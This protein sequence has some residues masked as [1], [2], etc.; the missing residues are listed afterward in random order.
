V[1]DTH[2][3]AQAAG[4]ADA[5]NPFITIYNELMEHPE[6][7]GKEVVCYIPTNLKDD[8][9]ALTNFVE[10]SD[11]LIQVGSSQAT[12]VGGNDP[13]CGDKVI[14]RISNCT[15]V[16]W[17]RLPNDYIIGTLRGNGVE[18]PL[19]MRQEPVKKLQGFF[20]L[21][22]IIDGNLTQT[23]MIRRAGFGAWN[24]VGACV[25]RVGNGAYAIPTGYTAPLPV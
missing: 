18:P 5:T 15:I 6:N 16:E 22:T 10:V 24:R 4:I 20:S 9:E 11:P 3:L 25:H 8:V 12:Y 7:A 17:G 1:T 23:N 19:V 21:A 13:G 2:Y 14:G